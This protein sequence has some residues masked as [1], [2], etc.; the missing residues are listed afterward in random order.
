MN[1]ELEEKIVS[2]QSSL[3]A[4]AEA[5]SSCGL[6]I[7][8]LK[9]AASAAQDAAKVSEDEH[10]KEIAALKSQLE[11]MAKSNKTLKMSV[12]SAERRASVVASSRKA[13]LN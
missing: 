9:D 5:L 12:D 10:A 11:D 3:D 6:E 8:S 2:L 4:K 13:M 1:S 7:K